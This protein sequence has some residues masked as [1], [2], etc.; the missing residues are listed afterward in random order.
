MNLKRVSP[1][2]ERETETELLNVA[3]PVTTI[4]AFGD[5]A[6]FT[7]LASGLCRLWVFNVDIL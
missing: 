1:I 6:I 3:I 7:L 5:I 2:L 4:P